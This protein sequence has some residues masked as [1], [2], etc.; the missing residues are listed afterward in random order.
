MGRMSIVLSDELEERFR[1]VVAAK[2]GWKKGAL[3]EAIGAA[4]EDWIKKQ[5]AEKD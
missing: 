4:V 1:K 5:Q 2:Y 3:S